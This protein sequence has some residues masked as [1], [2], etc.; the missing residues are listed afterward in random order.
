MFD[1]FCGGH[2]VPVLLSP[3]RNLTSFCENEQEELHISYETGFGL[4]VG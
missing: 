4:N 1:D 2:Q 3:Q